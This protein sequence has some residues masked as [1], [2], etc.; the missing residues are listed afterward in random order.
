MNFRQLFLSIRT[1][2][3][4]CSLLA[5]AKLVLVNGEEIIAR[6]Q[7]LDDLWQIQS[8]ARGYLFG[9]YSNP[10]IVHLPVYPLLVAA[11]YFSGIPL[12]VAIE[13]L[14]LISAVFFVFS[15]VKAGIHK[16]ICLAAYCLIIFHPVSFQLFNY[17]LTDT[18][19]APVLLLSLSGIIMMWVYRDNTNFIRHAIIAG[20]FLSLLWNLRKE[21]IL[22]VGLFLL[23][24]FL[25]ALIFH[26][27]GRNWKNILRKTGIMILI[28]G[29]IIFFVSFSIKSMNYIKYGIFV[30]TEMNAPGYLSVYKALQRIKPAKPIR[31]VPVPKEVRMAAYSVS[32]AFSELKSF[33]EGDFGYAASSETRKWMGIQ[34]EIA[35]GWFYWSL[36]EAVSLAGHYRSAR[37]AEAYYKRV[38][39][40]INSSI[41]D[42]RLPGRSVLFVFFDPKVS[43]YIP[44]LGE[45]FQKMWRLFTSVTDR[46]REQE[47]P[48]LNE[49]VRKA[50]DIVTN[51]RTALTANSVVTLS[52]WAFHDDEGITRIEL[53]AA[54]GRIIASA[55]KFA[56]RPDVSN[57]YKA[58]G[59]KH[60]P[61]NT[62]FSMTTTEG[63]KLPTAALIVTTS[64]NTE[65]VVP[66]EQTVVGKPLSASKTGFSR[67]VTYALDSVT[68]PK[69]AGQ[70]QKTMQSFLWSTY[71]KI[72]V[73]LTY[74]SIISL[75]I[76]GVF[77]R[78]IY[79]RDNIYVILCLLLFVVLSR[80]AL[81]ALIDASSW[82]GNQARYLFPVMPVYSCFLLLLITQACSVIKMRYKHKFINSAAK[83]GEIL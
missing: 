45:S 50:F 11:S 42:G 30:S 31:F 8:A 63:R 2:I 57:S 58:N 40:E 56:P 23:L 39:D 49:N 17:T 24:S 21:N 69:G 60:V 13:L 16:G 15:L 82:P 53:R 1:F 18:L 59:F 25:A 55:D 43:N 20:T 27:E 61:E 22:I 79:W 83:S 76:L 72:V 71:G 34:D 80:V 3:V 29:T 51:R 14:F 36:R 12:R 52:G 4:L 28:P 46:G 48:D 5:I 32:P 9:A 35:A 6:N 78:K 33:F 81:F 66:F 47:D 74:F 70:I 77:Y 67:K 73:Y 10:S 54:D 19:Y 62:G 26:L 75:F 38:A 65:Y 41:D 64:Q 37:E 44:Y 68:Q 7:P